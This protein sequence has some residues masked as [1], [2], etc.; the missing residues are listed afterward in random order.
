MPF[1]PLPHPLRADLI[2]CA[3]YCHDA[4]AC[5]ANVRYSG[6]LGNLSRSDVSLVTA[7]RRIRALVLAR[8]VEAERDK[9]LDA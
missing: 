5:S 1:D 2:F 4:I 3:M 8:V 7:R 9:P 6:E